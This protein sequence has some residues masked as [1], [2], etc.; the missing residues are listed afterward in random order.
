MIHFTA[1]PTKVVRAYQSGATD[2]YDLI[3]DRVVSDG[4]GNPCRHCLRDIPEGAGFLI[5]AHRPFKGLHPYAET[6]PIFLCADS[7][8]RHEDNGEAPSV[9]TTSPEYLIKGYSAQDR[10]V[11]GAGAV[12][13]VQDLQSSAEAVFAD[14]AV[15]YIHVRSSRNN[16]HLARIDRGRDGQRRKQR[17]GQT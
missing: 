17:S 16:C 3:P 6:G 11:Y 12:V 8:A 15:A 5:L 14:P 10:I 13:A 9:L 4:R 7:C 1:L 2:V